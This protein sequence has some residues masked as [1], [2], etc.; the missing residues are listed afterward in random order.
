MLKRLQLL[1]HVVDFAGG[2]AVAAV[3]VDAEGFDDEAKGRGGVE[4]VGE[5]P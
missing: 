2:V 4:M 1:E 5:M 3:D